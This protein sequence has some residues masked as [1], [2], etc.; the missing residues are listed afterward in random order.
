[1]EIEK[2]NIVFALYLREKLSELSLKNEKILTIHAFTISN[3][4]EKLKR[5]SNV[6]LECEN[7][8]FTCLG[9]PKKGVYL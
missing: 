1:M 4:F 2:K 5:I 6:G 9:P 3:T 8:D 7:S